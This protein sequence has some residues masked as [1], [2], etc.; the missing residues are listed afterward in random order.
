MALPDPWL[1]R[2][3]QE[4]ELQARRQADAM[5]RQATAATRGRA[6]DPDENTSLALGVLAAVGLVGFLVY[7]FIAWPQ[8]RIPLACGLGGILTLCILGAIFPAL[9][10]FFIATF[11]VAI[12]GL[13]AAGIAHGFYPEAYKPLLWITGLVWVG[14]GVGIWLHARSEHR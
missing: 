9:G 7:A 4:M 5:D 11:F 6:D 8:A 1:T 2:H 13:P 12:I 3:R 14:T 10:R